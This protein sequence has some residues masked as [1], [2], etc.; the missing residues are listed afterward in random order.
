MIENGHQKSYLGFPCMFCHH[1]IRVLTILADLPAPQFEE[2]EPIRLACP[3]CGE[4]SSYD[5][6]HI[7]R[8]EQPQAY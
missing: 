4:E 6:G 2:R 3:S 1:P 8:F 7:R 5:L